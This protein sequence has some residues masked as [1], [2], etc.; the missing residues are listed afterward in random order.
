ML[1]MVSARQHSEDILSFGHIGVN[2]AASSRRC[3]GTGNSHVAD[4]AVVQ[5]SERS[6]STTQV[7]S[8]VMLG[9]LFLA[10]REMA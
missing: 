6:R 2:C 9:A 4:A 10:M 1:S 7:L 5:P 3:S 8:L